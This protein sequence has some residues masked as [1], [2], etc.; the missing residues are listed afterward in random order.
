MAPILVSEK[1]SLFQVFA[2]RVVRFILVNY[3]Q[4]T[5]K[6][7]Y[8]SLGTNYYILKIYLADVSTEVNI[9]DNIQWYE[10]PCV[11]YLDIQLLVI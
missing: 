8:K 3:L 9:Y 10:P 1:G 4:S 2:G 11:V 5:C 6:T 7:P